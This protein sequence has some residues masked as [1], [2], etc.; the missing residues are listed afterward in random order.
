MISWI[1]RTWESVNSG[2]ICTGVMRKHYKKWKT[3]IFLPGGRSTT[4]VRSISGGQYTVSGE[5]TCFLFESRSDPPAAVPFDQLVRYNDLCS[6]KARIFDMTDHLRGCFHSKLPGV[7]INGGQLRWSQSGKKW[8][9]KGKNGQ[10]LR[11]GDICF[12]TDPL[13]GKCQNI[14]LLYTSDAADD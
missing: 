11:Y 14:C 9:V 1:L 3:G 6:R 7:N 10:I 4:N 8:V 12:Y 5:D 13:Q 2:D